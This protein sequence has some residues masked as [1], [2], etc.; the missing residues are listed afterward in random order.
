MTSERSL[1]ERARAFDL[2]ALTEIYDLFSPSIYRYA[3]RLIDDAALAEDCV[4]ETFSRLLHTLK[5][6][7][8]P[9][10]FLKAYLFRIAHNWITDQ[11]RR[12]TNAVSLDEMN[13]EMEHEI[14]SNEDMPIQFVAAQIDAAQVR[15]ALM[16]LTPDQR[17][18]IVLKFYE[19]F[20]N[21]EVAAALNKPISAVKSLQHRALDSLR[22]QLHNTIEVEA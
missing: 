12:S 13:E 3:A 15:L 21:E 14:A 9:T 4:T 17:Q 22:R 1:L 20:T 10:D 18:V 5:S 16:R 11:Y 2:D 8:G 19:A 6:N 7:N